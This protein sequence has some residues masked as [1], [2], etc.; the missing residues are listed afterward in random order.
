MN[1]NVISEGFGRLQFTN[2]PQDQIEIVTSSEFTDSPNFILEFSST[3]NQLII[4]VIDEIKKPSIGGEDRYTIWDVLNDSGISHPCVQV[5]I[6]HV[7]Y[8]GLL[9]SA[10]FDEKR[11][12]LLAAQLYFLL[13]K[14]PGSSGSLFYHLILFEKSCS[15]LKMAASVDVDSSSKKKKKS[16]PTASQQHRMTLSQEIE[17]GPDNADEAN[18]TWDEIT[19]ILSSLPSLLNDVCHLL[20]VYSLKDK[21]TSLTQ[22]VEALV[23]IL[24]HDGQTAST[25]QNSDSIGTLSELVVKAFRLVVNKKHGAITQLVHLVFRLLM[26]TITMK[27]ATKCGSGCVSKVFIHRAEVAL[28][29][30]SLICEDHG[31]TAHQTTRTLMQNVIGQSPDRSDF[32]HQT[33]LFVANFIYKMPVLWYA[34]FVSWTARLANDIKIGNRVGAVVLIGHLL[35][36]S[37]RRADPEKEISS[38]LEQCLS[39][40][41]LLK[42]IVNKIKDIAPTVRSKSLL[43]LAEVM[44]KKLISSSVFNALFKK[45]S[46]DPITPLPINQES[47]L[48]SEAC[49]GGLISLLCERSSDLKLT[50]RRSSLL[51]IKSTI[52]SHSAPPNSKFLVALGNGCRDPMLSVRKCAIQCATDVLDAHS[53][54]REVREMW[55]QGVF[56][57]VED[58]EAS[59]Q[60]KTLILME[61]KIL[62]GMI[63]SNQEKKILSW[64]L[65]NFLSTEKGNKLRVYLQKA[66]R[67]WNQQKKINKSLVQNVVCGLD[68][69]DQ[70]VSAW[71]T[72]RMM[73][74]Y[75]SDPITACHIIENW[76]TSNCDQS[77]I[78]LQV[79]M[80]CSVGQV[81][82]NLNSTDKKAVL[83]RLATSIETYTC[84]IHLINH[85]CEAIEKFHQAIHDNDKDS[86][87]SMMKWTEKVLNTTDRWMHDIMTSSKYDNDLLV[88]HLYTVGD[89]AQRHPDKVPKSLLFSVQAL[90]T[91]PNTVDQTAS[92]SQVL[93]QPLSQFRSGE[94][95]SSIRAHT[96]FNLGR[97]CFRNKKLAKKCVPAIA[98][99]LEIC[100][101]EAVRNN[102]LIVL[103]DLCV[104]ET[105]L[106]DPFLSDMATCLGDESAVIRKHAVVLIS[107]LLRRE[108]IKWKGTLL[109]KFLHAI[110]DTNS[111]IRTLSRYCLLDQ[112]LRGQSAGDLFFRNFIACLFYFNDYNGHSVHRFKK[113]EREKKLFNLSGTPGLEKRMEIYEFLLENMIDEHRINLTMKLCED[114]LGAVVDKVI[115]LNKETQ[116]ILTDCLAVLCCK[117][118]RLK[119]LKTKEDGDDDVI[120]STQAERGAALKNEINQKIISQVVKENLVQN[121]IPIIIGLKNMLVEIHSPLVKNVMLYLKEVMQEYRTEVQAI[122]T[123]DKQLASEIEFDLKRFEREEQEREEQMRRRNVENIPPMAATPRTAADHVTPQTPMRATPN[124]PFS[125][126]NPVTATTSA[127]RNWPMNIEG[128]VRSARKTLGN[129]VRPL[130]PARQPT[131]VITLT[132]PSVPESSLSSNTNIPPHPA[133]PTQETYESSNEAR[134]A[135]TPCADKNGEITFLAKDISAIISPTASKPKKKK[136]LLLLPHP[137][138]C[139]LPVPWDVTSPSPHRASRIR[140]QYARSHDTTNP[141]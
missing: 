28:H 106:V 89:L 42:V 118:I 141:T 62:E 135:S 19:R 55:V 85:T 9:A 16:A 139:P 64:D 73:T 49:V 13:L 93:S 2:I 46:A 87:T 39:H 38:E 22:L 7:L 91:N 59:V 60:E 80:I 122:L 26:T 103:T 84:P 127:R 50:V 120:M 136:R 92:N 88:T 32:R 79:D 113:S 5:W 15:A 107:S 99:E 47:F 8:T 110:C 105:Q 51:A 18:L 52:C 82:Q 56:T 132:A 25:A 95:P 29:G 33:G 130:T 78:T 48:I 41:F 100:E 111:D 10:T 12:C 23:E 77:L 36:Q 96:I 71:M 98:R 54:I 117:E 119:C 69:A 20:E 65:L 121:I 63:S 21:Q 53:N 129:V 97:I 86:T 14:Q 34:D 68:N 31:D 35:H 67:Q 58:T 44:D 128:I 137:E 90:L 45:S 1:Y 6:Y 133:T 37:E 57:R 74:L 72:L 17:I 76:K 140:R 116:H 126:H 70:K 24:K 123:S 66:I 40:K 83:A 81:A 3:T 101:N 4:Q 61:E 131:T 109:F 138:E 134:A 43:V 75:H 114:V 27:A 11:R 125:P 104:I 115:P 108:F 94:I 112:L 124:I 102:V 30:V